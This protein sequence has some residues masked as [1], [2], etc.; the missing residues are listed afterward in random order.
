MLELIGELCVGVI[1][2]TLDD[3]SDR[4]VSGPEISSNR[5]TNNLK[6]DTTRILQY[7][8]RSNFTQMTSLLEQAFLT[9]T[10]RTRMEAM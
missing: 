6:D 8:D 7:E 3:A 4:V 1:D 9:K 10:L 5:I 2:E